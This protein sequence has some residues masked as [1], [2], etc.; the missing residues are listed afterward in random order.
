MDKVD[1]S[2]AW[3]TFWGSISGSLGGLSTFLA[4]IGMLMVVFSAIGWL[5]QKR[6]GGGFAQGSSGLLITMTVG[7]CLA[8]PSALI[9]LILGIFDFAANSMIAFF[10]RISG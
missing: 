2:G 7:A 9:P 5:W 4:V 10:E 8:A 1:F 6:R 3:N